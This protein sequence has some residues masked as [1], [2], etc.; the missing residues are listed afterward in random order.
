LSGVGVKSLAVAFMLKNEVKRMQRK[1]RFFVLRGCGAPPGGRVFYLLHTFVSFGL[2][3][4][5]NIEPARN[6]HYYYIKSKREREH[7]R[8][9]LVYRLKRGTYVLT[10]F[11]YITCEMLYQ[12]FKREQDVVAWLLT[13]LKNLKSILMGE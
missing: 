13:D 6:G 7:N 2:S 9:I 10:L 12:K 3:S 4:D 1:K 5:Y 11:D 8:I